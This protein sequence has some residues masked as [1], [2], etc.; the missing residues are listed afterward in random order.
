MDVGHNDQWS[1]RV[2]YPPTSTV[3]ICTYFPLSS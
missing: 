3:L 1:K 2:R